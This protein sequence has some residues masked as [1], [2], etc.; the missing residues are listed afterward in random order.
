MTRPDRLLRILD[1]LRDGQ[2]HRAGDMALAL[3]VS[4]RTIYRDMDRLMA[5][6]VP[7]EGTRGA[8]YRATGAVT[9]P[10]LT[11]SPAEAEALTLGLAIVAEAADDRLRGAAEALASRIDAVLP[12]DVL[13]ES[14]SWRTALTPFADTARGVGQ[15][16]RIRAAINGRQKLRLATL[17]TDGTRTDRTVRPLTLES[18]GRFWTLLAW[19]EWR[20]DFR[21]FRLDLIVE[22][23]ALPELFRDEPGKTL[24]DY[25]S[26]QV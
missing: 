22:A 10:P 24:A 4:E 6:G 25:R 5:A 11:L 3:D 14:E 26:G 9:L 2:R 17:H 19:C 1:I 13:P 15:L 7:V 12:V 20:R 8:G 16:A 21:R 23:T 18:L